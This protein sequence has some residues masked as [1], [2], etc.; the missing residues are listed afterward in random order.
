[1]IEKGMVSI[2]T[3][4][5]NADQY[6][7]K[8]LESIINQTYQNFELI[9]IND[10][11]SDNTKQ[12]IEEFKKEHEN[13]RIIII[14]Q[15]NKGNPTA[16]NRGIDQASG[17]FLTFIDSDD[18]VEPDH[19]EV[20][21]KN[22][23]GV[24]FCMARP[25]R[26]RFDKPATIKPKKYRRYVYNRRDTIL[27][28]I[29]NNPFGGY[30]WKLLRR[31][32]IGDLRFDPKISFASDLL[33]ALQYINN[34]HKFASINKKTYH[35]IV[36]PGSISHGQLTPSKLTILDSL[37]K[38]KEMYSD[39]KKILSYLGTMT[40]FTSMWLRSLVKKDQDQEIKKRLGKLAKE[41]FKHIFR[42]KIIFKYF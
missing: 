27:R 41:N 31:E 7:S 23:E 42:P 28:S 18:Y 3:P 29:A 1:M 9:I 5:Y 12:I 10:G 15:E 37:A 38:I 35:Y 20:L 11:S 25:I 17:E 2:I 30:P 33:F 24:D 32:L 36:H 13:Y 8:C 21:V 14:N 40:F 26:E 4:T 39:D 22:I 16:V 6:I 19:L 34:G